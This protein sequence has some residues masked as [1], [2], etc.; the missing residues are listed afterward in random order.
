MRILLLT[1]ETSSA[2]L[3]FYMYMHTHMFVS[4]DKERAKTIFFCD[5]RTYIFQWPHPNTLSSSKLFRKLY[6]VSHN[7]LQNLLKSF[8]SELVVI[9]E[10]NP[11]LIELFEFCFIK[12]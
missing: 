12:I 11:V 2:I 8:K 9:V 5:I 7:S 1:V 10:K 6:C 3:D 4:L